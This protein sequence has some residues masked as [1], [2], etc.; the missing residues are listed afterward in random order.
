MLVLAYRVRQ[1]RTDVRIKSEKVISKHHQCLVVFAAQRSPGCA[2]RTSVYGF[3]IGSK[4]NVD[5]VGVGSCP[6]LTSLFRDDS[7][8][9]SLSDAGI[10]AEL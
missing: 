3:L 2:F 4:L 9:I 7:T 6:I 8:V 5:R 10:E 1:Y